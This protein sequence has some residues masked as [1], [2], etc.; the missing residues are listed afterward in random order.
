MTNL[1]HWNEF[2]QKYPDTF[3][4]LYEFWCRKK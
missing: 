2:E 1:D 3:T 4:G